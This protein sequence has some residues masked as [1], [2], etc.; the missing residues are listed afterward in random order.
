MVK[1]TY[2]FAMMDTAEETLDEIS[3]LVKVL[4]ELALHKAILARRNKVFVT[5]C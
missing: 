3:V 5:S 4:V 2:I 1:I